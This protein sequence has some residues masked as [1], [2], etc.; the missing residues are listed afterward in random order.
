MGCAAA[1]AGELSSGGPR[2]GTS[3]RRPTRRYGLDIVLLRLLEASVPRM[4]GGVVT[5]L[6][7][8]AANP[9][10]VRGLP[11]EPWSDEPLHDRPHRQSWARPGGPA[12]HLAWAA[13]RLC[14]SGVQPTG[15]PQQRKTWNL[16]TL[17]RLPTDHGP[18]WLKVV[19]DF[20]AHE[21]AI[22]AAIARPS[23]PRLFAQ[24]PGR[25]LMADLPGDNFDTRGT[26]LAPMVDRLTQIQ[27]DW[28]D[29]AADLLRLGL[30]DQQLHLLPAHIEQ[31]VTDRLP[32][33]TPDDQRTLTGLV[34]DLDRRCRAVTD[35]GV[36]E[37]FTHG[38]FHPGNVHGSS[39][40]YVIIDW[41]DSCL[42]HPL[43]DALAFTR[44]LPPADQTLASSW[45]PRLETDRTGL[46]TRTSRRPTPTDAAPH[47]RR[48]LRRLLPTHREHR[49]PLPRRR[50]RPHAQPGHRRSTSVPHTDTLAPCHQAA[51]ASHGRR[52]PQAARTGRRG[53]PAGRRSLD[54]T[55][56]TSSRRRRQ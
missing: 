41:G 39:P 37:T 36:P 13:D 53:P 42:S 47:R 25:L 27:A 19:P 56:K 29:R 52:P 28:I 31:L 8:T 40:D 23:V 12:E 6:A 34:D 15:V 54:E 24:E 5:Y 33:F 17:W 35:C 22:I 55:P 26:A 11:L 7:E 49:A 45:S 9:S 14:S 3:W 44:P 20:F 51:E 50:H 4:P 18:V 21:G 2:R 48:H 30:P 32:H 43:S 1:D 10:L 38:D 16:S 46:R